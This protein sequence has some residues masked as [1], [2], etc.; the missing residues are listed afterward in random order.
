MRTVL[1]LMAAL[2][3]GFGR[4]SSGATPT[5]REKVEQDE[6]SR[7]WINLPAAG[8]EFG[9]GETF[10]CTGKFAVGRSDR[11]LAQPK[12]AIL[13]G[14]VQV[15][16]VRAESGEPG[17]EG[18]TAFEAKLR[19]PKEPGTYSLRVTMSLGLK[20]R[21]ADGKPLREFFIEARRVEIV[22]KEAAKK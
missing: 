3:L 5:S 6:A 22:V 10:E 9:P 20:S 18:A 11:P 4:P 1:A 2:G 7:I 8:K 14:G 12:V 17:P 15:D 16:Q 19:C 13:S 21:D